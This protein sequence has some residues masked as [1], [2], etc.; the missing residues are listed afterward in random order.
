MEKLTPSIL[1]T[2]QHFEI[3]DGLRGLAALAVV[4]FHF[5]EMVYL[6]PQNFLAHGF[7]AVDF[8]F[9]LS[10]F[11]I[12]YAY[13]DR[14]GKMGAI[15]FFKSRAIRL[16]PL[17][18]LGSV[19]GLLSFLFDPF[20]GHLELYSAGKIMLV[21]I[22]SVLLIPYPVVADRAFNLFSFNAPAWSLFWEYVANIVYALVLYRLARRWLLVLTIV[23]AVALCLVTYRA[24]NIMGGW[25]GPNF[26]DGSARISYSFLAG[27]LVYRSKWII[28][29]NLGFGVLSI[30][31]ALP[32]VMPFNNLVW[33]TEPLVVLFY[34]PLIVALGAGATLSPGL[35]T[36][37]NFSGNISYPLYMTHYAV[38]WMFGNYYSSHKP[39]TSQLALIIIAGIIVLVGVAWLVMVFYDTPV[40]R[41]LTERRKRALR[42]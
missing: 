19:L 1:K 6:P 14:I 17:V 3:L 33:I 26:W 7:L 28:K 11:V 21:F 10:G 25:G 42:N 2:K 39:G 40:R 4:A 16:H 37:C 32:F 24:G 18:I 31:L 34:F 20:G 29:S 5:M 15:A 12:G 41:Y 13:D 9:C 27:L 36:L 23:S 22:S 38:I 8:F 35:K 30:L